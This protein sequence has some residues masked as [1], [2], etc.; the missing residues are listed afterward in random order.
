[1]SRFFSLRFV[2]DD[3][4][5][6]NDNDKSECARNSESRSLLGRNDRQKIRK[7]W[8]GKRARERERKRS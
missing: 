1:M 2:V 8:E 4:D 5:D 6:D 7:K 3:D